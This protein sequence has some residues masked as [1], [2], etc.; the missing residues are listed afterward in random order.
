MTYILML[1]EL[2]RSKEQ[3]GGL[4]CAKR[5]A[6]IKQV[7][8]AGEEGPAF[9]WADWRVIENAGFLDDGCLVVIVRTE[10]TL[11]LLF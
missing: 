7:D 4:L 5:L 11:F 2:R 3:R 6:N 8:N 1:E 9:P 10:T